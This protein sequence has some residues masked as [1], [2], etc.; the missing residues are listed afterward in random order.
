MKVALSWLRELVDITLPLDELVH[1]L[2]MSGTEVE[3]IVEVGKEWEG[4]AVATVVALDPHPNADSLYVAKLDV[5][6]Q[7]VVTVVTG[8]TNLYVGAQVPYIRPGG[9][10][11]GGKVIESATLRGIDSAGMV[12]S[13][14]ELGLSPD[15]TGIY[16]LDE[17]V[18]NGTDLRSLFSDTVL[19]LYITPNRPD[20]MSV[21]GV[22]RE[23]HA[24]TGAPLRRVETAPPGGS[25]PSS[26]KIAVS[27]PDPDL[28]RRFTAAYVA[29]VKPGPSPLWLQRRLHLAG[30]RPIS[31][32]VDATNYTMLELGQPQHAFDADALGPVVM[33]R[34]ARP[35]ERLVTLDDVERILD[36]EM[37]VIADA[38]KPVAVGG[39]MGGGPTEVSDSTRN[40]LLET[41]NFLPASIRKS[42][43]ALRLPSEASR[44]YER[45]IDPDLA[46]RAS[47]RTV[48]LLAQICGGTPPAD[49]VDVYPGK[50]E[51][52]RILVH[53]D[54]IGGLLGHTY[55]P[56]LVTRVLTS[57]DFTV[58]P[59]D[60]KLLVTVP[61]HRPDVEGRADLAEE[62]A[63]ITGYDE[64]PT[65]MPTGAPP[66]PYV[67][68]L[69]VAGEQAK[70][71]LVAS[72]LREVKTYSLV[73]PGSDARV[74]LDG[75]AT[76]CPDPSSV[77]TGY[78]GGT[79]AG[80]AACPDAGGGIALHNY[81]S[82][83]IS[84]LRTTLLPSLLDTARSTLRNRERVSI[85]EIA[86]VYLPP[87]NPLPIERMRLGIVMTGPATPVAWNAP[88]RPADFFDLKGAIVEL[89]GRFNVPDLFAPARAEAYHPGRCAELCVGAAACPDAGG[90]QAIGYLGQLHPLIAE[91]FDLEGREVYVAELDFDTLVEHG[92]G[93]P[94]LIQLARFP[95][96]DRD[97]ALVLGRDVPHEAVESTIRE[98]GGALLERVGLFDLYQGS[99]VAAGK[100]SL[101]YTL[102]FRAPDRTLTDAEADDA[103]S[104]I[105]AAV[106]S[107]FG[108]QVRGADA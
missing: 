7:G 67:E 48:A 43:A 91:R 68:P 39:I 89:L 94:Q 78:G 53:E 2:N 96:L 85:F 46:L 98:A 41:A 88:E 21:E 83:D 95:G 70:D 1:R 15:R 106:R 101:A 56:E 77:G 5:G 35:G 12:C 100:R 59:V 66:E 57:L 92:L 93:Q 105:T 30:V 60:T 84:V 80:A 49:I 37:L 62:I 11:P 65:T 18:E 51:P 71:V 90:G 75:A 99:Q 64:I 86:R 55:G 16:V 14:D 58:E 4:I 8:A 73:A 45:G 31:N 24:I 102:R 108:A 97:L 22:A 76:A 81:L 104:K 47:Q 52:K 50:A 107:R 9:R 82:T 61:G 103:M 19:D 34:R 25:V 26:E 13:A 28:C 27:I 32:V 10:L 74:R 79:A 69:L 29:N 17:R 38:E 87:L 42:S 63:R 3:D 72:G 33:A 44:R 54:E 36:P 20:T 40:V 6:S 23:I